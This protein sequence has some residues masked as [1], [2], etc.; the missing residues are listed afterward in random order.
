MIEENKL[1]AARTLAVIEEEMTKAEKELEERVRQSEAARRDETSARNRL[2]NLQKEF[3]VQVL[4]RKKDAPRDTDWADSKR[5]W[6][7]G[8]EAGEG[9]SIKGVK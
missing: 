3:D 4:K 5:N 8:G 7:P 2:N 9:L 6:T 1:K